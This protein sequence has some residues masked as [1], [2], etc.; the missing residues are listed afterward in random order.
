MGNF[1]NTPHKK[2]SAILTSLIAL[3]LLLLFS[4]VGL[5]YFDPP[6]SYGM[7]VNFGTS[8]QGKGTVQPK[9]PPKQIQKQNIQP[10]TVTPKTSPKATETKTSKVLTQKEAS[11]PVV[12][13]ANKPNPNSI[14]KKVKTPDEKIKK[15]VKKEETPKPTVSKSTKQV[16]S[17]LL[18][19]KMKTGKNLQG[20]GNDE[21]SGDK[22][23][24]D[25]NPYASSYYGKAGLGGKG[26]GFGLNGRSLQN[27]GSVTQECNQEGTVVVRI[28]VDKSGSVVEAEPGVKGTTN[29]DPCLLEPAKRT[30]LLHKWFPDLNAPNNQV[31]FVVV[32]FK[33]GE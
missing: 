10:K 20:E 18:N 3:L 11:I 26:S 5:S 7:E 4:W 15:E 31:G 24:I 17:N 1:L 29:S 33:L 25:G 30:A 23:K 8:N 9:L 14:N 21:V 22:G 12:K 6:I 19:P 13:K 32:K 16:L 28:I 27:Q 2:K